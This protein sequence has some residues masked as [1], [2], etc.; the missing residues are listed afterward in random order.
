MISVLAVKELHAEYAQQCQFCQMWCCYRFTKERWQALALM[1][2]GAS[3]ANTPRMWAGC[4]NCSAHLPVTSGL[5]SAPS[6]RGV[7]CLPVSG[8]TSL[9]WWALFLLNLLANLPGRRTENLRSSC[10]KTHRLLSSQKRR[11]YPSLKIWIHWWQTMTASWQKGKIIFAVLWH[12]A[13]LGWANEESF[14]SDTASPY[15]TS[16]VFLEMCSSF[17]ISFRG[18]TGSSFPHHLV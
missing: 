14:F 8:G 5:S 18:T 6:T 2:T 7:H 15:R 12:L 4:F 11:V 16:P 1:P 9:V 3:M 17:G 13:G 10:I